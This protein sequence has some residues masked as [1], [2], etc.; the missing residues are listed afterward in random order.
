LNRLK[1]NEFNTFMKQLR[2]TSVEVKEL[3][4][5]LDCDGNNLITDDDL[6]FFAQ[7]EEGHAWKAWSASPGCCPPQKRAHDEG[8]DASH[9]HDHFHSLAMASAGEEASSRKTG[10]SSQGLVAG[11]GSESDGDAGEVTDIVANMAVDKALF[12]VVMNE[13]EHSLYNSKRFPLEFHADAHKAKAMANNDRSETAPHPKM[14]ESVRDVF[15][16]AMKYGPSTT[17]AQ[18]GLN[19]MKNIDTDGSGTLDFW[20]V[21]T[22]VRSVLGIDV[23]DISDKEIR[24][25]FNYID[26]D[27][28]GEVNFDSLISWVTG[29]HKGQLELAQDRGYRRMH[30]P[31][32]SNVS[33][34]SKVLQTTAPPDNGGHVTEVDVSFNESATAYAQDGSLTVVPA[35]AHKVRTWAME[36]IFVEMDVFEVGLVGV[37]LVQRTWEIANSVVKAFMDNNWMSTKLA[38]G[39]RQ[40]TKEGSAVTSNAQTLLNKIDEFKHKKGS[41]RSMR[42]EASEAGGRNKETPQEKRDQAAR[43]EAEFAREEQAAE[44]EAEAQ[45]KLADEAY[46]EV[47]EEMDDNEEKLDLNSFLKNMADIFEHVP[48]QSVFNDIMDEIWPQVKHFR[49][50]VLHTVW[51]RTP[52]GL[53]LLPMND[54]ATLGDEDNKYTTV[55]TP[56]LDTGRERAL[57]FQRDG[58]RTPTW[59]DAVDFQKT[60][61][62]TVYDPPLVSVSKHGAISDMLRMI[63][64]TTW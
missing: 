32:A 63:A 51:K 64:V 10:D 36:A 2:F 15:R 22:A 48:K 44:A 34:M 30:R 8:P 38:R 3:F 33:E 28:H 55:D 49:K 9:P 46:G 19:L 26:T 31:K 37:S 29:T 17:T 54:K 47:F 18:N 42:S 5:C 16:D 11:E 25:M 13:E 24:E 1:I 60:K 27:G 58:Q 39:K 52:K 6:P 57:F 35:E 14:R 45:Q 12:A 41:A 7:F 50:K 4:I 40:V 59:L 53:L 23:A 61:N 62:F 20:E 43:A 56:V 21:Y